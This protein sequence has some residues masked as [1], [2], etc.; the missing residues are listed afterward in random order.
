LCGETKS[1]VSV[2]AL[3]CIA[4]AVRGKTKMEGKMGNTNIEPR[5]TGGGK[6]RVTV[7][8]NMSGKSPL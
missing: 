8:V 3:E 2:K 7:T 5:E 6:L 4:V 1:F